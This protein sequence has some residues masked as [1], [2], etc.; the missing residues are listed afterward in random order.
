LLVA[1]ISCS[2]PY[3]YLIGMVL[4]TILY[5]LAD[6]RTKFLLKLRRWDKGSS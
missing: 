6:K 3:G 1:L 4:G 5:Y 2:L